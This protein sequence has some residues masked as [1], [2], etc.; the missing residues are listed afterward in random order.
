MP[1]TSSV[2]RA[3]RRSSGRKPGSPN[4]SRH[5]DARRPKAAS[6]NGSARELVAR[7][8]SEVADLVV[9]ARHG[10]A[11]VPS[12]E[13]GDDAH[14]GDGRVLDVAAVGARVQV[15]AGARDVDLGVHDA[16]QA[17]RDG[18]LVALE[19]AGVADDREVGVEAMAVGLAAR[20]RSWVEPDSSSPSNT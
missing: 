15:L 2:G 12:L 1:L 7:P 3:P 13:R 10:D 11:A 17:D 16:A 5:A 20:R 18:R 19:E 6:S 14:E 9:E 4:S 8:A